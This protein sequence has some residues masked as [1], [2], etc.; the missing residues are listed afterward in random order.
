[1]APAAT[2]ELVEAANWNLSR[3]DDP[4]VRWLVRTMQ[5]AARDL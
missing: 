5:E 3:T 2:V 4:A 1:V